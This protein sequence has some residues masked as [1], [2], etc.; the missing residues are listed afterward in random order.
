MVVVLHLVPKPP[1]V[2]PAPHLLKATTRPIPQF[3][4]RTIQSKSECSSYFIKRSPPIA[5]AAV[6]AVDQACSSSSFATQ[7]APPAALPIIAAQMEAI[8]PTGLGGGEKDDVDWSPSGFSGDKHLIGRGP[9]A[10]ALPIIETQ[11]APAAD[12][13][14]FMTR[15]DSAAALPTIGTQM[16]P[17]VVLLVIETQL[18]PAADLPIIQSQMDSAA[19]LPT[20]ETQMAPAAALPVIETE[21]APNAALHIIETQTAPAAATPIIETQM[22]PAADLPSIDIETHIHD[23]MMACAPRTPY[24]PYVFEAH[25]KATVQPIATQMPRPRSLLAAAIEI[26][27]P[28]SVPLNVLTVRYRTY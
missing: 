4:P 25:P 21:I 3:K 22:A 6:P 10:A 1:K 19:A 24:H 11:L 15:M 26:P 8:H 7:M 14:N 2:P 12:L 20:I 9:S 28:S 16:A 18:A 23:I 5:T 17:A 13:P 27:T